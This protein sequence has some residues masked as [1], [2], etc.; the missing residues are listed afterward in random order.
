M[1]EPSANY[2]DIQSRHGY[3]DREPQ[4]S[5][6]HCFLGDSVKI[7]AGAVGHISDL[8]LAP[9]FLDQH[10]LLNPN[11]KIGWGEYQGSLLFHTTRQDTQKSDP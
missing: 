3:A 4:L 8:G 9:K 6:G 10:N 2:F 5:L 11:T 7:S 1:I